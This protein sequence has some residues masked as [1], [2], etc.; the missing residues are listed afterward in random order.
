MKRIALAFATTILACSSPFAA[1]PKYR[2]SIRLPVTYTFVN[3]N[4]PNSTF[5][6]FLGINDSKYVVGYYGLSSERGFTLVPS[7]S[8]PPVCNFKPENYPGAIDGGVSGI[9]NDNAPSFETVGY[10]VDQNGNY[11]GFMHNA[12]AWWDIDYPGTANNVLNGVNDNDVA[13]GY[14]VDGVGRDHP[15]IY[16][17]PGN[18][19]V[20]LFISGSD[21][22][23][24]SGINDYNVIV[25]T[26]VDSSGLYHGFEFNPLFTALNYP[27]ATETEATGINNYGG[28]AGFYLSA[29]GWHGFVYYGGIWQT[30][31]DPDAVGLTFV[32]GIN[33]NFDIV[34]WG[35]GSGT[36]FGF[37]ATPGN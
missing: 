24:A 6:W 33:D 30:F 32:G 13:A 2:P 3:I 9:N 31:D 18:Q 15:Y 14:Y 5:D 37:E 26:Y 27:G 8:C 34:G 36:I 19:F 4:H 10:W 23:W 28:I 20:P 25:G 17:Q 12:E 11:H 29:T 21:N 22:A 35:E 7:P 16:S 1:Q